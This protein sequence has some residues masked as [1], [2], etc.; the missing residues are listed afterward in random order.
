MRKCTRSKKILSHRHCRVNE[1]SEGGFREGERRLL[2]PQE[3]GSRSIH[4][5]QIVGSTG[6]GN[7]TKKPSAFLLFH[8]VHLERRCPS[9]LV[10]IMTVPALSPQ[11][12]PSNEEQGASD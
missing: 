8:R 4:R 9:K 12:I 6:K 5:G 2:S 10:V 1:G 3:Y 7:G 11:F